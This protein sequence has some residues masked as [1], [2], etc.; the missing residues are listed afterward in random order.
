M[1][2]L[3]GQNGCVRRRSTLLG[4]ASISDVDD[5]EGVGG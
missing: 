2:S 3:A 4:E 1:A 5:C